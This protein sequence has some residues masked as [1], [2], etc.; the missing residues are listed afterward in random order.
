M[1]FVAG[2]TDFTECFRN[3]SFRKCPDKRCAKLGNN[4]DS[5]NL[6]WI[7]WNFHPYSANVNQDS[8]THFSKTCLQLL[9]YARLCYFNILA[10]LWNFLFQNFFNGWEILIAWT[11]SVS[12]TFFHSAWWHNS[13][14]H[15]TF[16][17]FHF[18]S[19]HLKKLWSEFGIFIYRYQWIN[20]NSKTS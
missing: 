4:Y 16:R 5:F 20:W 7:R 3:D 15:F 19:F 10:V 9:K 11:D 1:N 8:N 12:T 13:Y 18:N 2:I 14:R 17:F 6:L